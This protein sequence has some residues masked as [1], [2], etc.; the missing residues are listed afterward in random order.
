M[1]V[2]LVPRRPQIRQARTK[3]QQKISIPMTLML[4]ARV[5]ELVRNTSRAQGSPPMEVTLMPQTL[6]LAEKLI[7][8]N[9]VIAFADIA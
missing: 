9:P 1:P 7:V 5:R 6:E 8:S 3:N 4:L 2:T